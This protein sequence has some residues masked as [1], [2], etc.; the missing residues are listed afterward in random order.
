MRVRPGWLVAVAVFLAYD[1]LTFAIWRVVGADYTD[2]VSE[3]VVLRR[4]VLP[5]A[6]GA[7]FTASVVTALGWWRP[8]MSERVRATPRGTLWAMLAG[9]ALLF[10]SQAATI[11]WHGFT[12]R[13]L[14]MLAAAGVLVGFNE[15]LVARGVLVTGL[16]AG[17]RPEKW[18][19]FW[20]LLLFGGMHVA[21]AFAGLAWYAALVQGVFAFLTGT[22]FYV[23]RRAS[24]TLL[25]PMAA[26]AVWD[27]LSFGLEAGDASPAVPLMLLP[28]TFV[29]SLVAVAA[30]L[31]QDAPR[32]P[33]QG[34]PPV[35]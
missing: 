9:L 35:D 22:G 23:L 5:L 32:G 2:L 21:N 24:G 14:G 13:H 25:L 11:Q 20:S 1:F 33:P 6:I 26:H 30:I 28:V 12:G 34:E 17:G 7:M 16:R 8:A 27:F 15:E 18:V 3:H 4:L 10:T 19:W 31:R 29:I